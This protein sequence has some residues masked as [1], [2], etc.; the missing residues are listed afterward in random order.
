M[1]PIRRGRAAWNTR[2]ERLRATLFGRTAQ[3][4]SAKKHKKINENT[5]KKQ[6]YGIGQNLWADS[7]VR[8]W[9]CVRLCA[10]ICHCV[11]NMPTTRYT[12]LLH[13]V[14]LFFLWLPE[15]AECSC[16]RSHMHAVIENIVKYKCVHLFRIYYLNFSSWYLRLTSVTVVLVRTILQSFLLFFSVRKNANDTD[17]F[18]QLLAPN[19]NW[20]IG[21]A[22]VRS[23]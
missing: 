18:R 6:L 1:L 19:W 14:R 8:V 10:C 11:G 3:R 23:H 9:M 2:A 16:E 7:D 4:T 20:N 17:P 22:S 13:A 5:F 12:I 15:H 21:I